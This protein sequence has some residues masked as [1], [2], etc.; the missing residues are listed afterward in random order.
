[1]IEVEGIEKIRKINELQAKLTAY[2]NERDINIK[3]KDTINQQIS[4]KLEI[5]IVEKQ[6]QEIE[7]KTL[8][9]KYQLD[10]ECKEETNKLEVEKIGMRYANTIKRLE[11]NIEEK[12]RE[13][14][15]QN[16][17]IQTCKQKINVAYFALIILI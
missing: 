4:K 15:Q 17:E 16:A 10:M 7:L 2:E 13:N 1:M 9:E 11:Q 12:N 3:T 6:N 5:L 8:K 14:E